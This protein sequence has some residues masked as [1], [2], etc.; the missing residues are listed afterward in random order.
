[1]NCE[2]ALD[3]SERRQQG[4]AFTKRL[5]RQ[6][7]FTLAQRASSLFLINYYDFSDSLAHIQLQGGEKA[8]TTSHDKSILAS[9]PLIVTFSSCASAQLILPSYRRRN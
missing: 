5:R 3:C 8:N 4:N 1:L 2:R 6:H 7:P 9:C